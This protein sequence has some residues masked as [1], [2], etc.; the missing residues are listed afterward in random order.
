MAYCLT[1]LAAG[2]YKAVDAAAHAA[3]YAGA[4][5]A[6]V[7]AVTTMADAMFGRVG[8]VGVEAASI[9]ATGSQA[10]GGVWLTPMYKSVDSD[11]FSAE[12][13]LPHGA[14]VDSLWRSIRY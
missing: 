3:T 9:S 13:V 2:N 6:A 10:N 7:A 11:G 14:D 8:A 5:Q 4:Q 12:V 1:V